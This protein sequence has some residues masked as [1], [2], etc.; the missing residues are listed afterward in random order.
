M[1]KENLKY[2]EDEIKKVCEKKNIDKN[3]CTLIAVSKT[4][5]IEFI[6][7]AYD[8]GI[9]DF[10]ENKV[11]EILE[12]YEQLPKDIRW[13]M[14]GHL[15]TNKVK[16]I[17]D[18]VEY[19]HSIDSLKLA[20]VID[21]E[22]KKKGIVVK[23]FLELNIVGEETKFGFSVEELNSIVEELAVFGNLRIIGLMIVA[24]FVDIAEKN[25]EIF[26]K[27][28]KI[29]VDINAKKIHNVEI[30]ELS[31]GMSGDYLVAIEEGSTFVRVGSSIFGER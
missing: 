26:K 17:L 18:K 11:Q 21:K 12:K 24:P 7:E 31:M 22:A 19:I 27:M 20:S 13:H 28:K 16:M 15:Q 4:K 2:I 25:R 3:T 1:I 29:A 30:S 10:G 14:I 6:K 8:Y 9:R 23:G 5:P